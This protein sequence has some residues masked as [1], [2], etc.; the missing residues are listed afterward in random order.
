MGGVG[1]TDIP[2]SITRDH[3]VLWLGTVLRRRPECPR[4]SSYYQIM[5]SEKTEVVPTCL[6]ETLYFQKLD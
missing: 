4:S 1:I 2:N 6:A 3:Q 5:F